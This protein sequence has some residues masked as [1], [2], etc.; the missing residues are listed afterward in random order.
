[1]LSVGYLCVKF[2]LALISPPRPELC[3]KLGRQNIRIFFSF[4]WKLNKHTEKKTWCQ[5]LHFCAVSHG[6]KKNQITFSCGEKQ[7]SFFDENLSFYAKNLV[8]ERNIEIRPNASGLASYSNSKN[9]IDF[10]DE[11][12]AQL[13]S[14][15]VNY[16]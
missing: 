5:L 9:L 3:L 6:G 10:L 14:V 11:N 15:S 7:E 4:L 12:Q 1:M 16:G 8:L 13:V 2:L